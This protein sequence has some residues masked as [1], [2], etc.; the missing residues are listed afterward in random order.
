MARSSYVYAVL[1]EPEFGSGGPVAVFTVKHELKTWWQ[2]YAARL[3]SAE[4][5]LRVIRMKDNDTVGL[6]PGGRGVFGVAEVARDEL[7]E[8]TTP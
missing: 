7:I 5:T 3:E 1:S 2:R 6:I 4:V 8:P